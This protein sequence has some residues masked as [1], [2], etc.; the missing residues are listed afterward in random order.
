MVLE[1]VLVWS[2]TQPHEV[3]EPKRSSSS[4]SDRHE[5]FCAAGTAAAA[6]RGCFQRAALP[7]VTTFPIFLEFTWLS[8]AR[9][10]CHFFMF[11]S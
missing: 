6:E 11:S 1:N 4:T 2:E 7:R 9:L 5:I 3:K 10:F 8:R